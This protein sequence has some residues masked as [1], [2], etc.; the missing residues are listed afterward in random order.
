MMMFRSC[1]QQN[2][3]IPHSG[4]C[5]LLSVSSRAP[6]PSVGHVQTD[7]CPLVIAG[8][9]GPQA[10]EI[11]RGAHAI[12]AVRAIVTGG[13]FASCRVAMMTSCHCGCG[14]GL[15]QWNGVW[16]RN[17]VFHWQNVNADV[18]A[19]RIA[20][21]C[22]SDSV[23]ACCHR[24]GHVAVYD[25]VDLLTLIDDG[26]CGLLTLTVVDCCPSVLVIVV[27]VNGDN[28]GLME[29]GVECPAGCHHHG[30]ETCQCCHLGIG[31][32]GLEFFRPADQFSPS[33]CMMPPGCCAL[34]QCCQ[35]VLLPLRV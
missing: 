2:T 16:R 15:S 34:G 12:L 20:S 8:P 4:G 7:H 14:D 22:P 5:H 10:F 25:H 29:N 13:G 9:Y 32:P 11:H 6:A 19:Q 17:D 28:R 1:G 21:C 31:S 30:N 24:C 26:Y 18:P 3:F 23:I 33:H 35:A 27:V